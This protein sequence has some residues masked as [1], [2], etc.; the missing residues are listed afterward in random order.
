MMKCVAL[1]A[2]VASGVADAA[3]PFPTYI[4]ANEP[5]Y[6][7]CDRDST[8]ASNRD[9]NITFSRGSEL[10]GG[11]FSPIQPLTFPGADVMTPALCSAICTGFKFFGVQDGSNCFCGNDYGNQGGK[12][13]EGDCDSPCPGDSS[14]MCGGPFR[15]S[16]YAQPPST[17]L[18]T[19]SNK[20]ASADTTPMFS[21]KC[22]FM[23][24]PDPSSPQP[25]TPGSSTENVSFVDGTGTW[26]T[27]D[28]VQDFDLTHCISQ[29]A[30][31]CYGHRGRHKA[32]GPAVNAFFFIDVT[33]EGL[34]KGMYTWPTGEVFTIS[35]H[36]EP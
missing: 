1:V 33:D 28:G 31:S 26:I 5:V 2:L 23:L 32:T 35:G 16:I 6:I 3:G 19:T 30:K 7:G 25:P 14:A 34:L 13:P 8:E 36:W 4:G 27:S 17:A 22:T 15:N 21:G 10:D 9:L 29:D 12:A 24:T 18:S 20:L 11:D